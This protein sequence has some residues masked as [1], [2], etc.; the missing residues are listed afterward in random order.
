VAQVGESNVGV[1]Q[2]IDYQLRHI[3][4]QLATAQSK[5]SAL[6]TRL[7]RAREEV[8]RAW[9]PAAEYNRLRREYEALGRELQAEGVALESQTAFVAEEVGPEASPAPETAPDSHEAINASPATESAGTES[10]LARNPFTGLEDWPI[11]A[12]ET[13]AGED[14]TEPAPPNESPVLPP[15]PPLRSLFDA[16]TENAAMPENLPPPTVAPPPTVFSAPTVGPTRRPA[17]LPMEADERVL[18]LFAE[19]AAPSFTSPAQAPGAA[20][21]RAASRPKRRGAANRRAIAGQG[22]FAWGE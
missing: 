15:P 4:E 14:Q 6:E 10:A 18:P 20:K 1:T 22:C 16:V 17:P 3:E 7:A 5:L 2:S 12:M 8:G 21:N 11:T 13:A 9:G 19:V